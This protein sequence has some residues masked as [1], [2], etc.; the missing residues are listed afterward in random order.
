MI[1][2][3]I[4]QENAEEEQKNVSIE[5]HGL[6]VSS[7]VP[8]SNFNSRSLELRKKKA[9]SDIKDVGTFLCGCQ[10]VCSK[11]LYYIFFMILKEKIILI[12]IT[13]ENDSE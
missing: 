12:I 6:K 1:L 11:I 5:K 8:N 10:T 9:H 3:D 13:F 7:N 2:F 4:V